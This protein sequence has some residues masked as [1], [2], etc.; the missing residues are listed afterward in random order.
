MTQ[1]SLLHKA[2]YLPSGEQVG[3]REIVVR[4]SAGARTPRGTVEVA[5]EK[6]DRNRSALWGA[7]TLITVR[8]VS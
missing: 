7:H 3:S 6:G 5:L 2:R 8:R 4:V 1:Q